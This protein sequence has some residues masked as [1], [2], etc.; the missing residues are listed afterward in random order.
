MN[1][2]SSSRGRLGLILLAVF[3]LFLAG[4][5]FFAMAGC[6]QEIYPEYGQRKGPFWSSVNGTGVLGEMFEQAGHTV[7]SRQVLSPRLGRLADCIVWVPNDFQPPSQDVRWWLESWLE[8][9]PGRTL[10]YVGR[11]FD[12]AL[13]YWTAI[14]P[15]APDGQKSEIRRRKLKARTELLSGIN[16]VP[17]S[18]DCEWFTVEGKYLPRKVRS[19]QGD[20]DWCRGID[21][22]RLEIELNRRIVPSPDA[23]VLLESEGDLLVS[24]EW[25]DD[26]RRIVIANGSFLLNLPLVNH[27]HRKLAGQLIEEVGP[28]R[29]T[30]VFLESYAG[31]PLILDRDPTAGAPTGLEIFNIW[32]TGW[33]LLHLTLAGILFCF[34][35]FAIF[36]R[37][38]EPEAESTSD[39]GQHIQAVGELLQR[40][41]D[42]TYAMTRLVH[43]RQA[44]QPDAGPR[45]VPSDSRPP[46]PKA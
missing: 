10:I 40:S 7:Y 14:E 17:G 33:I 1:R 8:E 27:E 41:R 30:V 21:A 12:A 43:Y 9:E 35:R 45:S 6:N 5:V 19:L 24:S 38:R 31:G 34:S 26:S 16:V 23:E 28:P 13:W 36:G 11:D 18:E 32:P 42:T 3:G 22:S 20:P 2:S 44:V 37:P 29:Q 4:L 15:G 46:T 25:W 39:F